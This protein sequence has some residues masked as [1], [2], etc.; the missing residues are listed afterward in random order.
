MKKTITFFRLLPVMMLAVMLL[1]GSS[2]MKTYALTTGDI[3]IIAVNADAVKTMSFVA[4]VDIPVNTTISFTDNAWT[5]ASGPIA[6]TEGAFPWTATTAVSAGTVV[7][8][9][10]DTEWRVS[11]G[12]VT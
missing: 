6:T 8:F 12:S 11:T 10:L 4:L 1:A 7:K 5:S 3:V 9:T 2:G